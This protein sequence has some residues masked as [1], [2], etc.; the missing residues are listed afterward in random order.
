[1]TQDRLQPASDVPSLRIRTLSASGVNRD[2]PLVV[3]W[4]T[5]QRRA[6]WNF[7]L[8]RAVD[9]A[10]HLQKPLLILE[11]LGCENRWASDRHH[12]FAAQ[13]MLDNERQ[14]AAAPARYHFYLE[15]SA[16]EGRKLLSA[17]MNSACLIVA[18]DY[19]LPT[20]LDLEPL[21]AEFPIRLEK[22]DGNGLLPM[23]A[24][25][26]AFD[27][28]YAF[29]RFLQAHLREHLLDIPKAK[30]FS[31]VKLPLLKRL[32]SEIAALLKSPKNA[33]LLQYPRAFEDLP[34]DHSITPADLTGGSRAARSALKKFIDRRL[35][36]YHEK[37]GDVEDDASS[38]LS[39]YLHFGHLS[40]HEIFHALARR[41][42]W[43]PDG[44]AEKISGKRE[45]WWGMDAATEAF[46]EELITWRELG[47]NFCRHRGDY[48]R[49][50]SLP[51]WALATLKEHTI[52]KR[53]FSYS[54]DE[55]ASSATHDPLWNAAQRQLKR[56]GKIHNYLRM[57]WGKK[58]L[59]WTSCPQEAA[60]IMIELNNRYALD[61]DD[62]NSYSG[63]FW[64]LGRYDRPWGPERPIFGKIRYMS[65]ENTA[66]KM[67]VAKYIERYSE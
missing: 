10:K 33:S 59:E 60:A 1:M 44:L 55:F 28:A 9:W 46:L 53:E 67:R 37:R 61:G 26:K 5:A 65:S 30:P 48:S 16:G 62:P 11:V 32:P 7:A 29:R 58:I 31:R 25:G 22:V 47:F 52:D 38:G 20:S 56:E 4:M 49:Y 45:G 66:R 54:L 36:K 12:R 43:T 15:K 6:N 2:A 23:S 13:G 8:D 41:E 17:A 24:A 51:A 40:A 34:I 57:L 63:I 27:T 50:E 14:F 21:A 18:D 35:P 3:Y 39:P 19:P 42:A 64:V